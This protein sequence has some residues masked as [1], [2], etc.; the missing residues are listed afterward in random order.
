MAFRIFE[1]RI[2]CQMLCATTVVVV[3]LFPNSGRVASKF[4]NCWFSTFENVGIPVRGLHDAGD[5]HVAVIFA[6]FSNSSL[7]WIDLCCKLYTKLSHSVLKSFSELTRFSE[8]PECCV[9][10]VNCLPAVWWFVKVNCSAIMA[11]FG[12]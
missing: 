11:L 5:L 9:K 8:L 7:R 6:V 4:T 1:F 3:V 2:I 10:I 12:S